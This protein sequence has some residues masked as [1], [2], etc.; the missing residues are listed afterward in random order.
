MIN[1][2]NPNMFREK[3]YKAMELLNKKPYLTFESI[4]KMIGVTKQMVNLINHK[5]GVYG[6]P[7]KRSQLLKKE[8]ERKTLIP[9]R[10]FPTRKQAPSE[11]NAYANAKQRCTNPKNS[12]YEDYG[13][14]GIL[15]KFN[16]FEEFW[17]CL[18]KKTYPELTLDRIDNEGHYEAGNV[19]WTSRK[20]QC[21]FG[22]QR[23]RKHVK[24][25]KSI[26]I[27]LSVSS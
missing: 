19:Q 12:K 1:A 23:K 18:G 27:D 11:Y 3:Y 17:K 15:F 25:I 26:P 8:A 7:S 20:D 16:S 9:S 10:T 22:K 4:G 14:R 13:G 5:L 2:T 6:R 21:A 24:L